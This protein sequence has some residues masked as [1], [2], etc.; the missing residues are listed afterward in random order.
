MKHFF[1][2]SSTGKFCS[3]KSMWTVFSVV[4]I[5]KFLIAGLTINGMIMPDFDGISA[6]ALF[7]VFTAGYAKRESDKLNSISED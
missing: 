2:S 7:A 6:S 5:V 4:C 3:A 1:V